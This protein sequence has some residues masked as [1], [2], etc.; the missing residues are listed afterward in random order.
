MDYKSAISS[1]SRVAE[2]CVSIEYIFD[3][4]KKPSEFATKNDTRSMSLVY[5]VDWPFSADDV[6]LTEL[7]W[8]EKLSKDCNQ[9][10]DIRC[11]TY[12]EN[13]FKAKE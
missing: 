10:L 7:N 3:K 4:K 6:V 11:D 8:N 5:R 9:T 13:Q 12:I 1:L 2:V